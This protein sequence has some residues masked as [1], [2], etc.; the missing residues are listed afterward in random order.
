MLESTEIILTR[1][2]R[3]RLRER[4]GREAAWLVAAMRA[5]ARRVGKNTR[6]KISQQW[7]A[8][9]GET[10]R[11]GAVYLHLPQDRLLCVTD[12]VPGKCTVITV[13]PYE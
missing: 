4:T 9:T 11:R 1:H 12:I 13:M 5:H 7:R 3:E 2:A 6:R 8:A 10:Y